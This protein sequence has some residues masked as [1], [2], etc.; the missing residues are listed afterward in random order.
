MRILDN[1]HHRLPRQAFQ[2]AEQRL[3]CPLLLALRT[4]IRQLVALRAWQR[5]QIG[6]ECHVF[7]RQ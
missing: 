3:Q 1:H 7:F 4:E 2:P 6:E 5:Q